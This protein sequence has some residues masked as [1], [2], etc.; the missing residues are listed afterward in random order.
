MDIVIREASVKDAE[1]IA[2]VSVS[3]WKTAYQGILPNEFL[4]K[5]D[6]HSKTNKWNH[7]IL[8][9][10]G[11]VLVAE[12]NGSVIGFI[13][14]GS[15]RTNEYFYQGELYA[16]YLYKDYQGGGIGRR[17]IRELAGKLKETGMGSLL[18]WV[19]SESKSREF[20][21]KLGGRKVDHKL[22]YIGEKELTEVAYGWADINECLK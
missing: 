9:K 14:G 3:S 6:Y 7:V 17:L 16:I 22:I 1:E 4:T 19:L 21:E 5:L 10:Q 8:E 13:H 20:Y 18:V 12:E 2:K 11:K 15:E